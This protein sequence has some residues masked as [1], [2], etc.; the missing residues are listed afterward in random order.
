MCTVLDSA[1]GASA[2]PESSVRA[3]VDMQVRIEQPD[4]FPVVGF[5]QNYHCFKL[6]T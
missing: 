2:S 6:G 3:S 1:D 4:A 5:V